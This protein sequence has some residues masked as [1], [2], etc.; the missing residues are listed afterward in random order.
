MANFFRAGGFNMFVL[1]GLGLVLL[2]TAIRFAR[3]ADARRLAVIRALTWVLVLASVTGFFTGLAATAVNAVRLRAE[4]P[5][6]ELLLI[7]FAE[8]TTNLTLGGGLGVLTWI[9]VAVGLRRMPGDPS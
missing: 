4:H 1:A 2:W 3:G 5:L 9:L 6:E 8:S 7:G